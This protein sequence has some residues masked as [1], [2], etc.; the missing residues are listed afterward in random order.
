MA[1]AQR[2]KARSSWERA[3]RQTSVPGTLACVRT[4]LPQGHVSSS[5]HAP[6]MEYHFGGLSWPQ[7]GVSLPMLP[8]HPFAGQ[9]G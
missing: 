3:Q 5:I 8:R 4:A 7:A 1:L 2:S 9:P 6:H